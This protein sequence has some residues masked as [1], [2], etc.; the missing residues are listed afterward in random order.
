MYLL[1][2]KDE[3]TVLK[4]QEILNKFNTGEKIKL[5]R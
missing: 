4:I 2:E 3:L 1:D 5:Q